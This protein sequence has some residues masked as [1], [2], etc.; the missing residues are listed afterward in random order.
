VGGSGGGHYRLT[1]TD[2]NRI[3][4]DA[5]AQLERSRTDSEINTL[6]QR[7]LSEMNDRDTERVGRRLDE[8]EQALRDEVEEFERLLFGGSVAKHTYVDGLSDIDSLAL[9]DEA[10]ARD[11]SP[12]EVR[13]DLA[14]TL[15]GQLNM[16]DV[17]RIDIGRMAVTVT[18]RDGTTVQLLPAVKQGDQQAIP[19]ADGKE[20]TRI[21][22]TAFS[23]RLS[24]LNSEKAGAVVPAIKIAK[25][26]IANTLPDEERPSGYHVEALA[27]AAFESY[28]GPRTQR[29]MAERFF[30]AACKD[31]LKPIADVTGQSPYV[32][33]HLGEAGSPPRIALGRRLAQIAKMMQE[34][35]SASDWQDLIGE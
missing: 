12:D 21:N 33:A 11:R 13:E 34:A 35:R 15:K 2:V 31:V 9:I 20:W 29:A 32:D 30:S 5:E 7:E 23:D 22:P 19:S 26:I 8:I 4:E 28:N 10:S 17:E 1:P 6:L 18:Y 25:A 14:R 27:I 24:R 3:R 16:G